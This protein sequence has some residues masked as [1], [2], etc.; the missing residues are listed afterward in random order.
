MQQSSKKALI[1]GLGNSG[2]VSAKFL[3][4]RGWSVKVADTRIKPG[5]LE[6]ARETIPQMQFFGGNMDASL[7]EDESLVVISPGL[8]PYYSDAAA[9]VGKAKEKGIEVVG[10]IELFARELKRL[11][12]F[13]GYSPKLIAITGTNG[14]T[15]TTM[16]SAAIVAAAGKSVCFAGNVGPNALSELDRLLKANELPEYWVLELSSFQLD[17]TE[18]LRCTSAALL[19]VTEDH[20]DWHGSMEAYAASKAKIFSDGCIRIL[21]R[22]DPMSLRFAEGAGCDKVFTFGTDAPEGLNAMGLIRENGHVWLA[23]NLNMLGGERAKRS[24][25]GSRPV[26]FETLRMIPQEKLPIRGMHNSMNALAASAL[27]FA[28]GIDLTAI[29]NTL[30]V[31]RGEAHRVQTALRTD[32]LEFV[33]DSKGT[34]VGATA[35]ALG[36]FGDRKIVIILG[37]DGKGQDFEP[38][39]A[40]LE[41]HAR[42][43]VLIGRDAPKFEKMLEGTSLE[44]RRA[45]GMKGAVAECIAM[46]QAG[47]VVLLSPACASWDMFKD[48]ADRSE[49]FIAAARELTGQGV[50]S[51]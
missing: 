24:S 3:S 6:K 12:A 42:G 49:Q 30:A 17:T 43:V 48:Y 14:K 35:A 2:Y 50:A 16:L 46:A 39:R 33:D 8:S 26:S 44:V 45:S 15:T 9:I 37:G 28:A 21:N 10:E 25:A 51:C 23:A 1:L 4:E 19:N 34:N 5:L 40:P 41:A 36:G 22:D 11:K 7:L 13:R 47:D 31:Y 32:T 38:L 27:C 29:L 18:S 20:I